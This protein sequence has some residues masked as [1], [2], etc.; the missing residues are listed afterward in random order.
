MASLLPES[1]DCFA[2][3]PLIAQDVARGVT[4]LFF[5]ADMY[6]LCEV[7]LPNGRGGVSPETVG[8][9]DCGFSS[10]RRIA[11]ARLSWRA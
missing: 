3:A 9:L 5:R 7:P 10:S 1:P 4:R 11:V 6:A 8:V 2:D